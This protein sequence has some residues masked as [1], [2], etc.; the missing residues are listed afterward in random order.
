[1]MR[2]CIAYVHAPNVGVLS[3]FCVAR[4]LAALSF[5]LNYS[6]FSQDKTRLTMGKPEVN[7]TFIPSR[8]H[9]VYLRNSARAQQEVTEC[10]K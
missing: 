7:P 3:L 6:I 8:I 4:V 10:S 2:I 5:H 1:M 9:V